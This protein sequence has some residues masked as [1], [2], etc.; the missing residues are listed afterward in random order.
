MLHY[1]TALLLNGLRDY[2]TGEWVGGPSGCDHV[3][4]TA[5]QS[6]RRSTLGPNRDGLGVDNA[7]HRSK[8]RQ[9]ASVCGKCGARRIDQQIGLENDPQT[10]IENL[11]RVFGQVYRVL[12]DDGTFWLNIADTR[13]DSNLCGI[14]HRLVFAL[15]DFGWVWRDE[16]IW[17]APNKMPESVRNRCTKSH[18]FLFM[19]SKGPKYY[20]DQHAIRERATS[21]TDLGLLRSRIQDATGKVAGSITP[22]IKKRQEAGIDSR[23]ANPA[24]YANKRSV[25][26]IPT[27]PNREMHFA[28]FPRKLV[29]P[30]ILAGTSAK[31]CCPKCGAPYRRMLERG[32]Y[33][34]IHTT[35]KRRAPE[36]NPHNQSS[37][38]NCQ[39]GGY[40]PKKTIGWEPGCE[41]GAGEPVPCTVG[42]CFGGTGTT[43]AVAIQH[44]RRAVTM[45]LN[46]EY[47]AIINR[48]VKKA[49]AKKGFGL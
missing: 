9:F 13:R 48:R 32:E 44:G 10:Y 19:F 14:P 43:A 46:P 20:Y 5:E 7:A 2:G 40:W 30:C 34:K 8:L 15:Q 21:G 42:D 4:R 27:E 45:D 25:W 16:I 26:I 3:E 23:T 33:S 29:L 47:I 12:R 36:I 39:G 49:I 24:G 6:E 22:T 28:A 1:V 17:H 31:G 35:S 41:C 38:M 11:V 18:E 37:V